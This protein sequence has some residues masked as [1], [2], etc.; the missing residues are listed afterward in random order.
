[1][2]SEGN[3]SSEGSK[4]S[5]ADNYEH[6]ASAAIPN[7]SLLQTIT[8]GVEVAIIDVATILA[9]MAEREGRP[10]ESLTDQFTTEIVGVVAQSNGLAQRI[11]EQ[12]Q[13]QKKLGKEISSEENFRIFKEQ[14]VALSEQMINSSGLFPALAS[15]IDRFPT[16]E[17]K[18]AFID[19]L[20][21]TGLQTAFSNNRES[22]DS[23]D[24][25]FYNKHETTMPFVISNFS[26]SLENLINTA[27]EI[28]DAT[29][30]E[31]AVVSACAI[32][33]LIGGYPFVIAVF[34][35]FLA[36]LTKTSI[37]AAG[38]G[39]V[40]TFTQ[41]LQQIL[42]VS[43]DMAISGGRGAY[44]VLKLITDL[45]KFLKNLKDDIS[46][47]VIQGV[48]I[49]AVNIMNIAGICFR[50]IMQILPSRG[51]D[52]S[53][54]SS[55]TSN[56]TTITDSSILRSI[57]SSIPGSDDTN[58]AESIR[59]EVVNMGAIDSAANECL[60][61]VIF[62]SSSSRSSSNNKRNQVYTYDSL[63]E[64]QED[65]TNFYDTEKTS[66]QLMDERTKF[67]KPNG[68]RRRKSRRH[69]KKRSTLKRRRMKRRRTRKGKKR[70]HTRKH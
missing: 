64:S 29:Q 55:T 15:L 23:I 58:S 6:E 61:M 49:T 9:N 13:D 36:R 7:Q 38:F 27:F 57:F 50:S 10:L 54:T 32:A 12:I 43:G 40:S 53:S 68:G 52:A 42:Q 70:R 47:L 30:R 19:S 45:M 66:K 21:Q 48:E 65:V 44:Y 18:Q 62:N 24:P 20:L 16:Q 56:G 35:V 11:F 1:M 67:T 25:A 41:D 5:Y 59:K 34:T 69:K 4:Y 26:S 33:Y 3:M 60:A 37:N 14:S 39:N 22:M 17:G 2:S 46:S 51:S 28:A 8:P 31:L 63:G